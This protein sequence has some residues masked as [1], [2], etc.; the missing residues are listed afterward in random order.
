MASSSQSS[1][2]ESEITKSPG[3]RM[4]RE[5]TGIITFGKKAT[6]LNLHQSVIFATTRFLHLFWNRYLIRVTLVKVITLRI[7]EHSSSL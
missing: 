5:L 1:Q 4:V 3:G 2:V 6:L 7:G